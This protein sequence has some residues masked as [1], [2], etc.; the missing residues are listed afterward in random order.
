MLTKSLFISYTFL[1]HS[2]PFVNQII[3]LFKKSY[4]LNQ[5]SIPESEEDDT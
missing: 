5:Q 3:A 1:P 2:I 4:A